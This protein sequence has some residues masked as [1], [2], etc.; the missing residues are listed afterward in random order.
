MAVSGSKLE[1]D[2]ML[3]P[4]LPLD[5]PRPRS[6]SLVV[7]ERIR[8]IVMKQQPRDTAVSQ[9]ETLGQHILESLSEVYGPL[10]RSTYA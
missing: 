8:A 10:N 5:F 2:V 3:P 1:A 7:E 6:E 9:L 4:Y